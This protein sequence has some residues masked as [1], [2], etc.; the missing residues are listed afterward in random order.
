MHGGYSAPM[1]V[2]IGELL[3]IGALISACAL[4]EP[5]EPTPP[6]NAVQVR[7]YTNGGE[8]F[9]ESVQWRFQSGGSPDQ[10]GVVTWIPEGTCISVGPQWAL[11]VL[12]VEEGR[13]PVVNA[14]AA[15][16]NFSGDSP[17]NLAIE[18]TED[19]RVTISEGIPDWWP[20]LKPIGCASN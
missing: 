14:G 19:G 17:L 4:L 10:T 12:T 16:G 3:A 1:R 20:S 2:A 7:V 8:R 15:S 18:R 9:P 6:A 5:P 13:D 11:Q